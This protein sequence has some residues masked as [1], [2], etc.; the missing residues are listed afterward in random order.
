MGLHGGRA[1]GAGAALLGMPEPTAQDKHMQKLLIARESKARE[2]ATFRKKMCLFGRFPGELTRSAL[3]DMV[4]NAVHVSAESFIMIDSLSG[5]NLTAWVA[6]QS[7][8]PVTAH[9]AL[10][11]NILLAIA[12]SGLSHHPGVAQAAM[13]RINQSQHYWGAG[14]DML[15]RHVGDHYATTEAPG[16]RNRLVALVRKGLK[17]FPGSAS[18]VSQ[19]AHTPSPMPPTSVTGIPAVYPMWTHLKSWIVNGGL[20]IVHVCQTGVSLWGNT[21]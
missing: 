11:G 21:G 15:V 9:L 5:L 10:L 19:D 13:H 2:S 20:L 12:Y 4:G 17:E 16:N 14:V 7:T 1:A 8:L 3:Q 6:G 18:V